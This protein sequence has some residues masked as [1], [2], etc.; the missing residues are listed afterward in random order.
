MQVNALIRWV[1]GKGLNAFLYIHATQFI[2][3]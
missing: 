3:I 2:E 1:T